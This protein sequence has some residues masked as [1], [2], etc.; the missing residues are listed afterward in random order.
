MGI[1]LYADWFGYSDARRSMFRI[2]QAPQRVKSQCLHRLPRKKLPCGS[3]SLHNP[4]PSSHV[5]DR[6]GARRLGY[7]R[8]R[9]VC[10]SPVSADHPPLY[11][12]QRP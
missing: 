12:S 4:H 5:L 9:N 10:R 11:T 3:S 6:F 7:P 8:D 1:S 2:R